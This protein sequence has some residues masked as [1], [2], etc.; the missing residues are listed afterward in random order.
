MLTAEDTIYSSN[1]SSSLSSHR[2]IDDR[3]RDRRPSRGGDAA[4]GHGGDC[5]GEQGSSHRR[6]MT[7]IKAAAPVKAKKKLRDGGGEV[8]CC[9]RITT[10]PGLEGWSGW[11]PTGGGSGSSNTE[12]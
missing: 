12:R 8:G 7:R 2:A 9:R 10:L 6:R 5:N 4:T 3:S 11:R 1:W